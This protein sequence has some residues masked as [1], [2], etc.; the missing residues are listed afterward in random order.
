MKLQALAL[1]LMLAASVGA[2]AQTKKELVAKL[3]QV[4]QQGIENIGRSLAAQPAQQMLQA[5]GQALQRL[6]ADKREAVG[7]EIQADVKKFHEEVEPL[8]RERALRLAPTVA[9]PIY[10]EKLT[11]DELKQTIAWMESPTS[12]KIAQL[13][14]E[15]GNALAEK[16]VADTRA[17]VDGK[18]KA[19]EASI[20][21]RLGLPAAPAVAAPPASG[22]AP[23]KK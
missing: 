16:V 1:T 6:P 10:E 17:A 9:G 12:R 11:E 20:G 23:K 18:L 21:K 14:R 4:Q 2:Q 8:L 3:L 5:A 7:R 19:L 13:D 22:A 15:L